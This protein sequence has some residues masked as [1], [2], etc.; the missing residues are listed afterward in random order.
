MASEASGDDATGIY[1]PLMPPYHPLTDTN[2]GVVLMVV[3][4]P[5]LVVSTLIVAVKLW[6]VY[7]ITRKLGLSEVAIIFSVV[8]YISLSKQLL[9]LTDPLDICHWLHSMHQ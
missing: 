8:G 5:V 2:K 3:S 6:T 9:E 7:G 4:I 1:E